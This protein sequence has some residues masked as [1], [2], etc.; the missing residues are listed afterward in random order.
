MY[1]DDIRQFSDTMAPAVGTA[2]TPSVSE[3][4]G[5]A[6]SASGAGSRASTPPGRRQGHISPATAPSTPG[7]PSPR[8]RPSR[9]AIRRWAVRAGS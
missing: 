8:G 7:E 3:R 1:A 4:G 9:R 2:S 5:G 6:W